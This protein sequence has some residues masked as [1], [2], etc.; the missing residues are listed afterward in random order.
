[1]N[2]YL[3][4][5]N[6]VLMLILLVGIIM[7]FGKPLFMPLSFALLIAC[8]L[9]PFNRWLEKSG[10]HRVAAIAI[11]IGLIFVFFIG[12]VI[13][14]IKLLA[15]FTLKWPLLE[16][17]LV[18]LLDQLSKYFISDL[19]ISS[20]QQRLWLSNAL[21][22]LPEMLL[23]LLRNILYESSIGL[24]LIIMIPVFAALMLYYRRMLVRAIYSVFS[25]ISEDTIL[26]IIKETIETYYN[27]IK[28]MLVVYFAVG[29]LNSIGLLILGIPDAIVYGFLVAIMT[30]IPYVGI[31]IASTL[32]ITVAWITYENPWYPIAVVILFAFV[33]YIEANIIFPFAVSSRLNVNAMVTLSMILLGGLI[34]GGAGMILFIPFAAILKLI[35]DHA[36]EK[37]VISILFGEDK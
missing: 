27:F 20:E 31:L 1:M 10:V 16:A 30:F 23:P 7:Y 24:V 29:V 19:Q 21:Q 12:L 13:L 8:I 18:L 4:K 14:F 32:P 2:A 5:T 28:G 11:S 15:A 6:Q 17:K 22:K 37:N 3:A 25:S 35:A 26:E 34:W 33:Q 36:K 9:Y